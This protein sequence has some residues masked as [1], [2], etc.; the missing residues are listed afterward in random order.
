MRSGALRT[1]LYSV[2]MQQGPALATGLLYGFGGLGCLLAAWF[3][4]MPRTPIGL[5]QSFG[6]IGLGTA[7]PLIIFRRHATTATISAALAVM[8]ALASVLVASSQA[9]VGVVLPGVF[10][11][12]IALTAAS[13]LSPLLARGQA[14]LAVSGFSAGVLASGVPHL[15]VPWFVISV[16]TVAAAEMLRHVVARLRHQAALD[17]LTGLANR[18]YFRLAAE[19][20]LVAAGRTRPPFSLALLDL[21]NF[22]SVNDISGHVAGDALLTELADAWQGQL[23]K[24]DLLARYG[25]DEFALILPDT[26]RDE[27]IDVLE[28]L[29]RAH[30]MPWSAG[31]ATCDGDADLSQLL[32]RADDDLY[33]AKGTRQADTPAP[34]AGLKPVQDR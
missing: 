4:M 11:L 9:P 13:F 23:R 12:C 6:V 5:S 20:E 14:G 18:A 22:K 26:S 33:R 1:P 3:P 30:H 2:S 10:Y 8:T 19:R 16:V 27:A 31:V 15:V 7:L 32:Q 28:R 17:P 24:G 25:G 21:D 29:R 34:A